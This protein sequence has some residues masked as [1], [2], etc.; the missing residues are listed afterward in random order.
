MVI[1]ALLVQR[2][3]QDTFLPM[4][5]FIT[6]VVVGGLGGLFCIGFFSTRTNTAGMHVGIF[7]TVLVTVY[8]TLSSIDGML[9]ESL[10]SPTHKFM[11]GVFSN[12]TCFTVAYFASFLF[13]KPAD[14]KLANATFWTTQKISEEE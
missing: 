3:G 12:I 8:L 9:P 1:T 5:F 13:A 11:I 7:A 10:R 4:S 2:A 6:S 14:E